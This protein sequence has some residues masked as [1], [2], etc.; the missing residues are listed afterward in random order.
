MYFCVNMSLHFNNND[1]RNTQKYF[2]EA[3]QHQIIHANARKSLRCHRS[4]RGNQSPKADAQ[5]DQIEILENSCLNFN[6]V[7]CCT[8]VVEI[9]TCRKLIAWKLYNEP[10]ACKLSNY[11]RVF[12]CIQCSCSI[13]KINYLKYLINWKLPTTIRRSEMICLL[14]CAY[15][16]WKKKKHFHLAFTTRI[17]HFV[18]LLFKTKFLWVWA[19]VYA[20]HQLQFNRVIRNNFRWQNK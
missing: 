8:F 10:F 15:Q 9:S 11:I 19:R 16:K 20:M 18:N 1:E 17:F 4:S 5:A 2:V 6:N 13:V 7:A 14:R 12:V 3:K